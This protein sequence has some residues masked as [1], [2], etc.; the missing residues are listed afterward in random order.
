MGWARRAEVRGGASWR[1]KTRVLRL[2]WAVCLLEPLNF[3]EGGAVSR[4]GS[5]GWLEG[6]EQCKGGEGG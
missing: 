5:S 3:W 2:D 6:L 1:G 4:G